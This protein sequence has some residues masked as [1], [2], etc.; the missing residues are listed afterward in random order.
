VQVNYHRS[1]IQGVLGAGTYREEMFFDAYIFYNDPNFP[2]EIVTNYDSLPLTTTTRYA[3]GQIR[4]N[5]ERLNLSAGSRLS[6]HSTSGSFMTFELNPSYTINNLLLYGSI[7]TGFNAPSLYQLYDPSKGFTAYATRGNPDLKAERSLSLEV[8]AKKEF[9]SGS[10]LTI[11]A[12]RTRVRNSIEYIYLWNG[13]R[14]I[15]N[16]DF[17]DDRGDTYMNVSE[18]FASGLELDGLLVISD[19]FSL[20]GNLTALHTKVEVSAENIDDQSTGGN[21]IQ[22]YNLGA[23]LAKDLD[24]GDLVRRP[25]FTAYG[26]IIFQPSKTISLL[27]SYRCTGKRF[28]SGFDDSLGPYGALT[29]V[30]VEAYNLV[31]LGLSWQATEVLG[32]ALKAE[33]VLDEPYREVAGFNTRGRS[34]YVKLTARW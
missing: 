6:H 29:K 5:L 16:L 2:F 13:A 7:S 21:H 20:Q 18:Q 26:Q 12:F 27:A 9:V 10:Y 22:L 15:E 4:Y 14:P 28:D 19:K 33:N 30:P 11:S 1:N 34:V 32:I 23:F 24:Q 3:F 17:T 31:D 8:G 25:D